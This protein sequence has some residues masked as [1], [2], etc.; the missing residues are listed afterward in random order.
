MGDSLII[1]VAA[2]IG[3]VATQTVIEW[4]VFRSRVKD[5]ESEAT[6][7]KTQ[8]VGLQTVHLEE[9]KKASQLYDVV[10]SQNEYIKRLEQDIANFKHS[11]T[12]TFLNKN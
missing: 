1:F 10:V 3:S 8:I 11:F 12:N 7:H 9:K 2:L 5:Y 4:W 6:D